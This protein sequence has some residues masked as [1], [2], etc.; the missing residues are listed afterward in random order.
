M[1]VSDGPA[2]VF[3]VLL[4]L[5]GHRWTALV[6]PEYIASTVLL[7]PMFIGSLLARPAVAAVV[8]RLRL[9]L[10]LRPAGRP[11][12]REPARRSAVRWSP[13]PSRC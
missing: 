2:L 13:S 6:Y 7:L 12:D 5:A 1:S 10:L 8:H 4:T 11:A 3:L 9:R